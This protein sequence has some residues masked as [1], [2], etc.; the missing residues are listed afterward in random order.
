MSSI[1]NSFQTSNFFPV[2]SGIVNGLACY[3]G[4]SI[5]KV[6]FTYG[7][8]FGVV[9][10]LVGRIAENALRNKIA[11]PYLLTSI[12]VIVGAAA[13][14]AASTA[15]VTVGLAAAPISLPGAALCAGVLM[16][17]DW[18]FL[19]FIPPQALKEFEDRMSQWQKEEF[20]SSIQTLQDL[21][22]DPLMSPTAF[23][24]SAAICRGGLKTL[25]FVRQYL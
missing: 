24:V 1:Y 11:N 8:G 15:A 25:K 20:D 2:R 18:T 23:P 7:F 19:Y 6:G 9:A 14:Y 5:T 22:S 21:S 3:F 13:G 16:T 12:R 4:H 10:E 17:V